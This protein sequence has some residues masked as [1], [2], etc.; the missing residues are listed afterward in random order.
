MPIV[1]NTHPYHEEL[2]KKNI[3]Y[4]GAEFVFEKEDAPIA[5]NEFIE[6]MHGDNKLV[7]LNSIIYN[8]KQQLSGGHSDDTAL[9]V[10]EDY[11]WG[12][13]ADKNP[14]FIQTDWPLMM[15]DYLKKSGKY[16][17]K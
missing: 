11:G 9:T 8:Y 10:S 16:Y 14:D 6:K 13:L 12:W 1:V 7:W 3:N 15:I 5:Q 17:K 4:I 2:M